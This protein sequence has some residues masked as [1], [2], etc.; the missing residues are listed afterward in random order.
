[1]TQNVDYLLPYLRLKIGDI[2]PDS[3]RYLDEWLKTS[4]ILSIRSLARRWESKYSV[5][6]SGIVSRNTTYTD[7][8]FTEASGTIQDKDENPILLQAALIILEGSLENSAWDIGSW[9]DAEI[10]VSNIQQGVLRDQT[11]K[12]LQTE[13]DSILRPPSKRLV[14]SARRTFIPEVPGQS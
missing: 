1:M 5:T 4:L 7:W 10:S 6:D 12:N 9:R 14:V 11:I 13:L 8:E 2:N 3:Y